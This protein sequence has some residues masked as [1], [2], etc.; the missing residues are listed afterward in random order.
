MLF[1]RILLRI[2]KI[3]SILIIL[4]IEGM[5]KIIYN[6]PI[7]LRYQLEMYGHFWSNESNKIIT[8]VHSNAYP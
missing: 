7:F 8:F 6:F 5:G 3:S 1:N 4:S 2:S